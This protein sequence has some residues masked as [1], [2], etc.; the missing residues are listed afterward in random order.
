[1]K[2]Y[3][4]LFC[5]ALCLLSGTSCKKQPER[6]L[7]AGSGWKKIVII[8]KETKAIEWE[9]PLEK[10]WE[11]NSVAAT[12]KGNILF[13]YRR[14]V[15]L[16]NYNKEIIWDL[17]AE[18]GSEI[19]TAKVL[20]SGNIMIAQCGHPAKIM[21]LNAE[22]KIISQTEFE[23]PIKNPHGQFRQVN[24]NRQGNYMVPLMGASEVWEVSPAGDVLK[25]VKVPGNLFSVAQLTNENWLVACGDTHRYVEL[26][27]EK[28][29]IVREVNSNDIENATLFFVA[30]LL[31]T[32]KDGLYICNWQGHD[33]SASESNSPQLIELDASGKMIW[34]LNDNASFGMISAICP[35]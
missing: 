28:G 34:S 25:K 30:Q 35:M 8:D 4:L 9:Y 14:G 22:G 26:D 1:M 27:F 15:R 33:K 17:K 5:S 12:S 10:G 3:L 11:C 31:P 23:T 24:K 2:N 29:T 19:Q 32:S 6:L 13:S 21:E 7:L 20:P 18:E 16:I